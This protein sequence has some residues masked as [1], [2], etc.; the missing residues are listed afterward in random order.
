MDGH[1]A[2][3]V[4]RDADLA[5]GRGRAVGRAEDADRDPG[6]A[7]TEPPVTAPPVTAPPVTA[8]PVT[9]PPLT[10][11]PVTDPPVTDPVDVDAV[12][13]DAVDVDPTGPVDA[14]PAPVRITVLT[15]VGCHLC[16]EALVAIARVAAG[17]GVG[18]VELDVDDDPARADE[19]GDRVPV[20]MVDGR[21]HGYWRVEEERLRRALAGRRWSLRGSER[22]R[23]PTL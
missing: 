2:T 9:E 21:E 13:V 6:A 15:R 10:D 1:H 8:P 5:A 19:Y 11:P 4:D 14:S 20:I 17:E 23:E 22:R 18:W 7:V 16:E 12:D 3:S